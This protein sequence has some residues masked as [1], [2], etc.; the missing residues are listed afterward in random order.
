MRFV[1]TLGGLQVI[2][3]SLM[4]AACGGGGGG[5][6]GG[7]TPNR[8]P[9]SSAGA[10]Q[11]V[12]K[13]AAVTLDGSASSDA[14]G[15]ALSYRWTQT[16]G[17]AVS[18]SSGTTARPTF[19]APATSGTLM[20]SLIVNDGRADST[21]DIVQV[22]VANRVP[23]AS[24]GNDA[25]IDAGTL[26]T[27]DGLG[28]S[29]A[30]Q[31]ALTYTWTQL[32][33]PVVTLTAVSNGR[34]R[35]IAPSQVT[36]LTFG[37]VANDGEVASA[38]DVVAVNIVISATNQRP[39][40]YVYGGYSAPKRADVVLYGDGYDPE[41]SPITY[42]WRQLSG[43]T[44]TI[45]SAPF[46][47]PFFKAPDVPAV[48]T[49]EFVVSDGV[50]YS[51]PQQLTV[52]IENAAPSLYVNSIL[53]ANPRT[54]DDITVDVDVFDADIDPLTVTYA[55]KRNG[56]D[57]PSV[58]GA[59]FPASET[60]R[61]DV[62]AVTI[63]A[64]D[65][66]VTT[67]VDASTAIEDTPP[68]LS[69]N[70]PTSVNFGDTVSFQVTA[71]GDDDG[72]PVSDY[73]VRLGPAGIDVTSGGAVSW[74][75][76]PT[77]FEDHMDIAWSIGLRDAPT[78]GVSG[79]LRVNHAARQ[80]PIMRAGITVQQHR[81]DIVLADL[82]ANGVGDILVTDGRVL[83][84]LGK[85][86]SEYVEQW[87]YPFS[88]SQGENGIS[89][90]AA[91]NVA[92]DATLE[93]FAAT[94]KIIRQL[95]G[96]S[97][98]QIIEYEDAQIASC[99]TLRVADLDGNG[100][101]E[102]VCLSLGNPYGPGG[103]SGILVLNAADLTF[104]GRIDQ[105]GL[106]EHLAVGN[107]D[108]DAAL[109]IV[110]GGGFVYDGATL[111]NQWAYGPQ[112][113]RFVDTGDIDG[114]GIQEIVANT[115]GSSVNVRIYDAVSR[116]A[117]LDLPTSNCCGNTTDLRVADVDG[118][119]RAEVLASRNIFDG[120]I[121]WKFDTG[122][123]TFSALAS[124][125][126]QDYEVT[127]LAVGNVDGDARPEILWATGIVHSGQDILV[128]SEFTAP[129][130]LAVEWTSKT[131]GQLDGPFYGGLLTRTGPSDSR[132]TFLSQ[133]T[134][135]GYSGSRLFFVDPATG[136]T[137]MSA[138]ITP[139]YS[140]TSVMEVADTDGDALDE[141]LFSV[142][143]TC[144]SSW[145]YTAY[146]FASATIEWSSPPAFASTW[147]AAHADFTGDGRPELVSLGTDGRVTVFDIAQSSVV[148]QSTVLVGGNMDIA[149]A[150]LD[151]VGQPEIVVLGSQTL[152]VYGRSSTSGPFTERGNV[153]LV[154]GPYYYSGATD[155]LVADTDGDGKSE[156]FVMMPNQNTYPNTF[157]LRV[158]DHDLQPLRTL[159][160]SK[161]ITN[162]ALEP[163]AGARK[164]LLVS[165]GADSSNYWSPAPTEV[166]A[167]DAVTGT[168]VWRS[169]PFP[170][171]FS[172]NSLNTLD[173]DGNGQ[174]E[175]AF[176]TYVGGFVTR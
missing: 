162:L 50:L 13:A 131:P 64:N 135:N 146:D 149:V 69:A 15:N 1:H 38:Q 160:L 35:F 159:S 75:A 136:A 117:R 59:I 21:A 3:L 37:V 82:D 134:T 165:T 55:W 58:T 30:D 61:G 121:I 94:G 102:L 39:V 2:A 8:T 114:D 88:L 20:F 145:T 80:Q 54:L 142:L 105:T 16:S 112:F 6:S 31:D 60:T 9:V 127:G 93:I 86:G 72:D 103:A 7:D 41:N 147:A 96:A 163:S 52:T 140:T 115:V 62:I 95:S 132:V 118:D 143:N 173:V 24:A 104:K 25:T 128:V 166:W 109:E 139:S 47:Y 106:G 153:S 137:S 76:V 156:I 138:D 155:L 97:Y 29:D 116:T 36:Q 44:V 174:Y 71:S 92:G 176:G 78:A 67:S 68:T 40:A 73:V 70:A 77:M 42:H 79:T 19:N 98:A 150:D 90:I 110:T 123:Q 141:V 87:S 154:P 167:I 22:T 168:G 43:P 122:T 51:E 100:Q 32:S 111:A 170:G 125:A 84:I 65:G 4:L 129:N 63:T 175:L 46:S 157:D 14:D 23:S 89:A 151:H 133:S 74:H 33:G 12:F 85:A 5:G 171:E 130:T 169:P 27:L 164:N 113:G 107:V 81:D 10:D 119:N 45:S 158:F 57:V 91:G 108:G 161:R 101:K 124:L 56:T 126:S 120:V 11:S 144:C 49:F 26:F 18:L 148:W 48:L 34:V 83:S 172:R 17:P 53:P 28:S 66:T 99:N 152:Y